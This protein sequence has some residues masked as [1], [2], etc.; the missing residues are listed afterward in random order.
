MD[1]SLVHHGLAQLLIGVWWLGGASVATSVMRASIRV[2]RLPVRELLVQD[3]VATATY[4][5]AAMQISSKV[6]GWPIGALLATSGAAAIVVGLALQ[7][8]LGDAFPGLVLNL[9]HPYKIGD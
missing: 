5:L 8:T 7:S 4:I 3:I 6:F 9:T 2:R 1:I